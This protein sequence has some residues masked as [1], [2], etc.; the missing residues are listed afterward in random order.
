MGIY[1]LSLVSNISSL[2]M[3]FARDQPREQ[4]YKIACLVFLFFLFFTLSVFWKDYTIA[5]ATSICSTH[6]QLFPFYL[7]QFSAMIP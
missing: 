7:F 6:G 1:H 5:S 4:T 2:A 3:L